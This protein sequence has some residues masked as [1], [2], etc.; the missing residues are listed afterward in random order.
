M[1]ENIG[2]LLRLFTE[3]V[4]SALRPAVELIEAVAGSLAELAPSALPAEAGALLVATALLASLALLAVALAVFLSPAH[5]VATVA[6]PRRAI[7][8]ATRLSASHPD[9]PGHSRPRAPGLA[10]PAA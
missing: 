6:H 1:L 7:A 2:V 9:A 3:V 5:A 4:V 8:D 10:A